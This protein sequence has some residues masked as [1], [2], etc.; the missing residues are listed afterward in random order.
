MLHEYRFSTLASGNKY[1]LSECTINSSITFSE[2]FWLFLPHKAWLY[3]SITLLAN[4]SN[5]YKGHLNPHLIC[6]PSFRDHY[7]LLSWALKIFASCIFLVF[8]YFGRRINMIL[9]T[10]CWLEAEITLFLFNLIFRRLV[11][12]DIHCQTK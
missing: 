8:N 4:T 11:H 6:F 9:V 5:N 7:P 12:I 2:D 10:L 3:S 1:F